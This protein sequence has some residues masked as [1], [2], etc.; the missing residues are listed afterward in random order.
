MD[1]SSLDG[2][3]YTAIEELLETVI[4]YRGKTPPKSKTGIPTLTAGNVKSGRIDLRSVSYVSDETYKS[5]ITRGLPKP[6]DVLITTEAP[7]GEVAPFPGDQ[8]YLMTRRVIALRGKEGQLDNNFLLYAL[9]SP[10]AQS[11]FNGRVRGTTVPRVLKPDI[12][13]M[14]LNIPPYVEQRRISQILSTID[15]KIE[16]NRQINVTLESMAQALF[17]SWFVNFDPVIDNAL[18]AGNPI[19]EPLHDRAEKRK[20]LGDQRKP[21]PEHI[22]SQFPSSFVF[23][24]EMGWVPNAWETVPFGDIV[25]T[26]IGGDWGKEEE[27]EKHGKRV[28][29]IRGTDIPSIKVGARGGT[30]SRWVEEKKFKSRELVDG[31]IVIEISGGSPKQ[32]TGRAVYITKSNL[33]LF[34]GSVVP[35]SFCRKL[36]PVSRELGLYGG[37]HL[38]RIYAAGK[39]WGY[40]NQSTGISNFQTTIFLQ[41]EHV[42][43][44]K[45]DGILDHFFQVVRPMI[46]KSRSHE[47]E[48]LGKIRD[49]LLPK[50]LSGQL[51][52]PGP[53]K[54]LAE[55]I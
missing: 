4:D 12:L 43:L 26:T 14:K 24:E 3:Q 33:D 53:E 1:V 30:P 21:L 17:K 9:M 51:R 15:D 52:I 27:D 36:R 2:W 38:D 8:T 42:L 46:D 20:A 18:E 31:D 39:M 7:V 6:N 54:H 10:A 47:S 41:T 35:A 48:K 29:I 50:L 37:L 25:E 11:Y 44:P 5:W 22:Q 16:L 45:Q 34:G 32:P 40:Q 28:A 13:G 55:G 23:S 19:P 49:T